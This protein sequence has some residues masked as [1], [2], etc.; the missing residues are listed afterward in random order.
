[1][2]DKKTM[3]A[4]E[5]E[6]DVETVRDGLQPRPKVPAR[7]DFREAALSRLAAQAAR[8]PGLEE[9]VREAHA[10]EVGASERE[11]EALANTEEALAERDAMQKERDEARDEVERVDRLYDA[12]AEV[13]DAAGIARREDGTQQAERVTELVVERDAARMEVE[14]LK[15]ALTSAA[16]NEDWRVKYLAAQQ[17]AGTL[18][19]RVATLEDDLKSARYLH[20]EESGTRHAAEERV[21]ELERLLEEARNATLDNVELVPSVESPDT[22]TLAFKSHPAPTTGAVGRFK[23]DHED[24]AKYRAAV[25]RWESGDFV[26]WQPGR[27][28]HFV[29]TGQDRGPE[30]L[31]TP[32]SGPGGGEHAT[33]DGTNLHLR[34]ATPGCEVEAVYTGLDRNTKAT[35]AGWTMPVEGVVHCSRDHS[36][37]SVAPAPT[38]EAQPSAPDAVW[39]WDGLGGWMVAPDGGLHCKHYRHGGVV[40]CWIRQTADYQPAIGQ[41]AIHLARALAEAKREAEDKSWV[42]SELERNRMESIDITTRREYKLMEKAKK[43]AESM[44][45]RAAKAV[46]DVLAKFDAD[47]DDI[48][49]LTGP[50]CALAAKTIRALSL[51]EK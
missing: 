11:R 15:M 29:L 40:D 8:V 10:T 35:R 4:E 12:V 25:E 24:A 46:G 14:A 31:D 41:V 6:R 38:Q 30:P 48:N 7:L 2:D 3:T 18:R 16:N 21:R 36:T 17:D 42:I 19:E 44:R 27:A 22:W 34:C 32:P 47:R 1:M 26:G 43:A 20:H 9:E 23:A 28:A 49:S 33:D 51:E 5:V 45:E 39:Q 37:V 13:L 50:R